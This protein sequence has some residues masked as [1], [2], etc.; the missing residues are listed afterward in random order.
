MNRQTLIT[1]IASMVLV[2]LGLASVTHA[3]VTSVCVKNRVA[4]KLKPNGSPRPLKLSSALQA[5]AGTACP[6]GFTALTVLPGITAGGDLT[7]N[8][9]NPTIADGAVQTTSF[10]SLPGASVS[11]EGFQIIPTA[12]SQ[13]IVF[14]NEIYDTANFFA[15]SSSSVTIPIDGLYVMTGNLGFAPNATGYR[16]IQF[17]VNGAA[18]GLSQ[19]ANAGAASTA[20]LSLTAIHRLSA[21]D[22]VQLLAVQNSGGDLA[23]NTIGAPGTDA[24][25][26]IQ[27]IAP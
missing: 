25:F 19:I 26:S 18:I 27:W 8:Y 17:Q 7:G 3:Q 24:K 9:P 5:T 2:S 11:L 23:T 22:I 4:V 6:T 15:P 13:P 20:G 12:T 16:Q 1:G 10:G 21:A 14:D